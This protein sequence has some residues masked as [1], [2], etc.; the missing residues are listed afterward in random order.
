MNWFKGSVVEAIQLSKSRKSIFLVCISGN[1][2]F[3]TQLQVIDVTTVCGRQT[4]G[5][6]TVRVT[7]GNVPLERN[8]ARTF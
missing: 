7:Y 8:P 2:F 3:S 6:H 4:F 1:Y 5:R